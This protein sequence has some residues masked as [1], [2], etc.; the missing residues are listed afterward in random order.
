M[1]GL[2]RD[3]YVAHARPGDA[4]LDVGVNHGTH[5]VQMAEAVGPAGHVI[6]FEAAPEMCRQTLEAI[7]LH[8]AHLR[9]RTTLY[10]KAVSDRLGEA[11]FFFSKINDSGLSS[12]AHRDNLIEGEYDEITVELVTLDSA[13]STAFV[14]R[15]T[16]A[17]FDIEGAEFDA[18]RGAEEVF[19]K[20]P[21]IAFEWDDTSPA[22]FN[23]EPRDL[24]AFVTSFGY[25]IYDLFGFE[26]PHAE[27]LINAKVWNFV[28]VPGD[29]SPEEVLKPSLETIKQC[30]GLTLSVSD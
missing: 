30:Y 5:F 28:A 22:F 29:V 6:G 23:Y 7:A 13:L 11:K 15:L 27:N 17:K 10:Q 1:E 20:R 2:I 24:H 16:F 18:F 26:Y 14:N 8:H 21:L 3:I 9:Q 12:L 4:M 25:R 19:R